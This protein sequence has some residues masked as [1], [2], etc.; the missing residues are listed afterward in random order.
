MA[1]DPS[2]SCKGGQGGTEELFVVHM[3]KRAMR[4]GMVIRHNFMGA[5]FPQ[6]GFVILLLTWLQYNLF[7][8]DVALHL[9]VFKIVTHHSFIVL[10]S[11]PF[12]LFRRCSIFIQ[13]SIS[14]SS[15]IIDIRNGG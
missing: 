10:A 9:V 8:S 5:R 6:K 12:F 1:N 11:G 7:F 13:C 3:V 15:S 14:E 2:R 4:V